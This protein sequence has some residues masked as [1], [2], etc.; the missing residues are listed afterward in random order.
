MRRRARAALLIFLA[1]LAAPGCADNGRRSNAAVAGGSPGPMEMDE[2]P[3][4]PVPPAPASNGFVP[5]AVPAAP[6][7]PTLAAPPA[8]GAVPPPA[9]RTA[10]ASFPPPASAAPIAMVAPAAP[11]APADAPATGEEERNAD[12]SIAGFGGY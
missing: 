8:T 7:A 3:P 2:P 11:A 6:V 5:A 1:S 9:P 10:A 12:Q 4:T